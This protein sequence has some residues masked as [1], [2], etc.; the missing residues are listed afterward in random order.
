MSRCSSFASVLASVSRRCARRSASASG[1]RAASSAWRAPE[2]AASARTASA[3]ASATAACE[4]SAAPASVAR[5]TRSATSA[6]S[7]VSSAATAAISLSRRPIRSPC[8][9]AVSSSAW[10]RAVRSANVPVSSSPALSEAAS[11]ASASAT[12]WSTPARCSSLAVVSRCSAVFL[13]GE[14]CKR[15]FRVGGKAP[16][17]LDVVPELNKSAVELGHALLGAGLLA[18]ERLAGH[19]PVVARLRPRRASASRKAG[20]PAD[21]FAWRVE[22]SAC[23][24]VRSATRRTAAFLACSASASS[25]LAATQRRWNSVASAL[26]TCWATAR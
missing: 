15:G 7:C 10:R 22:A 18:L 19:R 17:A 23:S 21:A 13:G 25:A 8:S 6:P 24:P 20:S 11:T 4:V 16:L 1:P 12:R 14:P 5:S 9:R 3:S 26:R 2:C